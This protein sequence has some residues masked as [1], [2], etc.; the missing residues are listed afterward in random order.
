[1]VSPTSAKSAE[2]KEDN[3]SGQAGTFSSVQF[4]RSHCIPYVVGSLEGTVT[5]LFT[6]LFYECS[7]KIRLR[8][9]TRLT[10]CSP[11]NGM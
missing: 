2:Q 9:D 11:W 6:V 10:F 4:R 5:V 8:F 1:M 3:G 7:R